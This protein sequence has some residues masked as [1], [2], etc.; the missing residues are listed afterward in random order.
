MQMQQDS[1]Q[2]SA[3]LQLQAKNNSGHSCALRL[4]F[5]AQ[6]SPDQGS[7]D[8]QLLSLMFQTPG[9]VAVM[10]RA[11][12]VQSTFMRSCALFRFFSG[13]FM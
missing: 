12:R 1:S 13:L 10:E 9:Q 4:Q 5:E 8:G 7:F 11:C 3:A 6:G 2:H